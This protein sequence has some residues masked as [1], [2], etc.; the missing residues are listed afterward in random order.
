MEDAPGQL[1]QAAVGR[2]VRQARSVRSGQLGQ[3]AP[4]GQAPVGRFV[5]RH[6]T[7]GTLERPPPP[8]IMADPPRTLAEKSV[9][10]PSLA[11]GPLTE[12]LAYSRILLR[13]SR[14]NIYGGFADLPLGIGFHISRHYKEPILPA[15]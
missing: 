9:A 12:D 1:G 10:G 6:R 3:A 7:V 4:V 11:E 13:L 5:F 2:L 8:T 14:I 15:K